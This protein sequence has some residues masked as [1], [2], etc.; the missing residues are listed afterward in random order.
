MDQDYQATNEKIGKHVK[1]P[2][3]VQDH[4]YSRNDE[5]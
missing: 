3:T 4:A 2:S 1:R 5:I